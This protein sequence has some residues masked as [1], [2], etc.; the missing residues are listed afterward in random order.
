MLELTKNELQQKY[1]NSTN[2]ELAEELQI[3]K[4]TLLKLLR[5]NNIALKGKGYGSSHRV[6]TKIVV[7]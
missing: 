5:A 6:A 1:L 2:D 7:R 4:P 3:S